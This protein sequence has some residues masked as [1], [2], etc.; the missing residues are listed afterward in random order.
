MNDE[1]QYQS[2]P[3]ESS[4]RVLE[5]LPGDEQDEISYI[6]HFVDWNHPPSYEALS[7]TWGDTRVKIPTVCGEKL[8]EVMPNLHEGL[9]HLRQKACS[10][11]LWADAVCINQQD[12]D[13]RSKQVNN[14][15][16]IY[17]N[18]A[19]VVVW[20]GLDENGQAAI[21]VHA[22]EEILL[23]PLSENKAESSA[24]T[25]RGRS[26]TDLE[27]NNASTWYSMK[28]FFSRPW[29]SRLWVLQEVNSGPEVL[30]VCAKLEI[31]WHI[32][33]RIAEFIQRR[34]IYDLYD[35]WESELWSAL[36]IMGDHT[37]RKTDDAGRLEALHSLRRFNATDPR[38]KIYAVLGM[39][40]F[41]VEEKKD[42]CSLE[43]PWISADY[44]KS[45]GE[46][47]RELAAILILKEPKNLTPLSFVQST[48]EH[49]SDNFP[50]WVPRWDQVNNVHTISISMGAHG[51][52]ANASRDL[53]VFI[54]IA[55]SNKN[56]LEVLGFHF[57]TIATQ[58]KVSNERWF[59]SQKH[60]MKHHP[61][62]EF[63]RREHSNPTLYPTGD[64]TL[65]AYAMALTAG[66]HDSHWSFENYTEGFEAYIVRLQQM[67][68]QKPDDSS[69][70]LPGETESGNWRKWERAARDTCWNRTSFSTANGFMGVGPKSLYIGDLVC[71]LSGGRV[72]FILRRQGDMFQVI[73]ECY[74]Y[75]IM[76]GQAVDSMKGTRRETV[77]RIT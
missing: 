76:N 31:A 12:I 6:L 52:T 57:D 55:E 16:R 72:P 37:R 14:M 17:K 46:V 66:V 20:L 34:D 9:R 49:P 35:F 18:A 32:V 63:W 77:F 15:L 28:W 33:K 64:P 40:A 44:T 58:T 48:Q 21:A 45:T 53:P 62:L 8:L 68:G 43:K 74:V 54:Q 23:D 42:S 75:G 61:V 3:S 59:N 1:Y 50:S 38:D 56:V 27:C 22:M 51:L 29:F 71:V 65:F 7:Y 70:S 2:L 41:Q 26:W 73:G 13:E 67:E 47:Y 30:V 69:S 60:S 25:K 5:L 36:T 10:R 39:E 19:R 24:K 11:M 4:F